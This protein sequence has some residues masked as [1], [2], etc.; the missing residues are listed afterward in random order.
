MELFD[1]FSSRILS[2]NV[3]NIINFVK[4]D[5]SKMLQELTRYKIKGM[6]STKKLIKF[7]ERNMG[8]FLSIGVGR[9]FGLCLH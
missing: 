9:A 7:N 2:A 8:M 3:G 1:F 5:F 6:S 4:I